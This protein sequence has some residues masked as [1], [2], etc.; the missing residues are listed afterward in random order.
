MWS[1]GG[2]LRTEPR[3]RGCPGVAV[4]LIRRWW[5]RNATAAEVFLAFLLTLGYGLYFLFLLI[6]LHRAGGITEA[7]EWSIFVEGWA[8]V[9]FLA[10]TSTAVTWH[11]G[12]QY[13]TP[14]CKFQ[15]AAVL[16][17]AIAVLTAA[18]ALRWSSLRESRFSVICTLVV[19]F[20]PLVNLG[21]LFALHLAGNA[22]RRT[23][24]PVSFSSW[25][26]SLTSVLCTLALLIIGFN[27]FPSTGL[28]L[29]TAVLVLVAFVVHWAGKR[30]QLRCRTWIGDVL[31]MGTLVLVVFDP[32]LPFDTSHHNWFLG[33]ANAIMHGRTMLADVISAYGVG[34]MYFLAMVFSLGLVPMSYVGFALFTS[35]LVMAQYAIVY[36]LLRRV[37]HSV[38]HAI[39]ALTLIVLVHFVGVNGAFTVYPSAG[40]IRFGLPYLL[41]LL[42]ELRARYPAPRRVLTIAEAGIVALT[43]VWSAET[44]FYTLATWGGIVAYE[45]LVEAQHSARWVRTTTRRVSWALSLVVFAHVVLALYTHALSGQ[46]PHWDQYLAYVRGFSPAGENWLVEAIPRWGPWIVV[47]TIYF[48]SLLACV[49]S[50]PLLNTPREVTR[51]TIVFAMTLMGIAQFTYYLGLS[52]VYRLLNIAVP[53][54]FVGAFWGEE[55]TEWLPRSAKWRRGCVYGLS[56]LVAVQYWQP[57]QEWLPHSALATLIRVSRGEPGAVPAGCPSFLSCL[58]RGYPVSEGSDRTLLLLQKHAPG[59]RP[60]G[61]FLTPAA[62]T[63]VCVLSRRAHAFPITEASH[64]NLLTAN[65]DR[66]VSSPHGLRAG[67][68]IFVD[69]QYLYQPIAHQPSR[70]WALME[71][72]GQSLLR[73]LVDR[74]CK[75]YACEVVDRSD[76]ITV[77]RLNPR[78]AP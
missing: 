15:P 5:A 56:T 14:W 30:L 58:S 11:L 65:G 32:H 25:I 22:A 54:V 34:L 68:V 19:L 42:V 24:P 10:I 26:P 8:V 18:V 77:E 47:S 2:A 28:L 23:P 72:R 75:E 70:A 64:D 39:M 71:Q 12:E 9:P 45:A 36:L 55:V 4:S 27:R 59:A 46:W 29:G 66:I 60:I 74:L 7:E 49:Y 63:E 31:V 51:L 17:N 67:D 3:D 20:F 6:W 16:L 37:L 41:L 33:A 13:V 62:T 38:A 73:R 50:L 1:D 43:S 76:G 44:F 21:A 40:P 48:G 53:A 57:L 52:S 69:R 78:A 35:V 61:V